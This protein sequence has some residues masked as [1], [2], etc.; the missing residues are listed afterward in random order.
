M[1]RNPARL[2]LWRL[3]AAAAALAA[4][5]FAAGF[6]LALRG[7][8]GD[9][10]GTAPP[11]PE[12][13]RSF[14]K[15][16]GERSVL[17]LGDS[18]AKGTGDE[19]GK[20][21]AFDVLEHLRKNGAAQMTNLTVGGAESEDVLDLLGSSNVRSMAASAD[22]ILLSIG[23]NDLRHA[24]PR[25]SG[26]PLDALEGAN[27]AKTEFAGNLREI[28]RRLRESNPDAPVYLLG[29]Y[30]PFGEEGRESRMAASVIL[31]W[32]SILQE[33][34]LSFAR[35]FVVP[36]FDLFKE[37]PDRLA[38]D[39]FHPNRRGYEAIAERVMQLLPA[40]F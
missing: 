1:A 7:S 33:T 22:V 15:R 26:N 21:Y 10:I 20:G 14:A 24:L 29:L 19:T 5:L 40:N 35:V 6:Y 8:L 32:N 39:R 36:T 37:R 34:A 3:P 38:L 23:G 18:L 17:V 30:L 16:S 13:P 2:W 11:P 9:P 12:A 4:L 28:L 27:K 31:G 25:G